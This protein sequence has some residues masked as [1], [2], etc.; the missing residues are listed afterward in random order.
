M[1]ALILQ[2]YAFEFK[3]N[4]IVFMFR[5]QKAQNVLI[6]FQNVFK[7]LTAQNISLHKA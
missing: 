5:I 7:Y 2:K 6:I 3:K 1:F 4:S